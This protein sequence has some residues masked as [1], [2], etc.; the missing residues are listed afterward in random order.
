V[1]RYPWGDRWTWKDAKAWYEAEQA[2]PPPRPHSGEYTSG[3]Y[4]SGDPDYDRRREAQAAAALRDETARV[5]GT[6]AGQRNHALNDAAFA[7]YRFVLED[8]VLT[9]DQVDDALIDACQRN[10]LV[11]DDGIGSVRSTLRSAWTGRN[12][13]P[14]ANQGIPDDDRVRDVGAEEFSTGDGESMT[15]NDAGDKAKAEG[16]GK[17][18]RKADAKP[19]GHSPMGPHSSSTPPPASRR[20]GD[21]APKCCG[22]KANR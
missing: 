4:S 6:P 16:G 12:A 17:R 14:R 21:K 20:C 5:A 10:G 11:D 19:T 1:T 18:R 13:K 3:T 9:R 8:G 15:D 2:D 22:P 7:L